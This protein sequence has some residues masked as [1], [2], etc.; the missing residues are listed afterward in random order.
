MKDWMRAWARA[1]RASEICSVLLAWAWWSV[2]V[3][4]LGKDGDGAARSACS[5]G[6]TQRTCPL[7]PAGCQAFSGLVRQQLAGDTLL[8]SRPQ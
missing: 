1:W 8:L 7:L 3:T 2:M 6:D 5:S 4:F